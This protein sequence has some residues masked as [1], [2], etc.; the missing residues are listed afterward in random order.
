VCRIYGVFNYRASR[1]ELRAVSALQ[2]HGGPDEQTFAAAD[3]WAVG[4]NRLAI[5]E[6]DGGRQP[7]RLGRIAVVFNGELYNHADLR[8]DLSGRGYTFPDNCDGNVI[9]ALYDL[10][11]DGF[12]D[13]LDG[14]YAVAV[15]DLRGLPRLVL[16]TD[17]SGMKPLYYCRDEHNER[18]CFA[19]E[20]PALLGFTGVPVAEDPLG[21]ET[22][23]AG[24]TPFGER[25]MF[26]GINTLP[27]ASTA[28]VTA[29]GFSVRSRTSAS[30]APRPRVQGLHEAG[31]ELRDL[32]RTE[33]SRLLVADV[34]VAAVTSG[35]LDSSL[36]T[37]LAAERA[38]RLHTF[39]IAYA[40]DWPFD[41][42]HYA[43]E[44]ADL[45]GSEHHQVVLDPAHFG[46][47][48]EDVVWHLGQPNS[49]PISLSTYALFRAVR[50]AGF[51][52]ALTGDAADELFGGYA[53]M[54]EAAA[55]PAGA[56]WVDAYLDRLAAVPAALR[57]HLYTDDY[58]DLLSAAGGAL[59]VGLEETLRHGAGSRLD[60]ICAVEQTYRLPA[61][62]LRRV[63]HLSMAN[64]VEVRLPYCQ[65][66]VL[67]FAAGLR[68][69]HRVTPDGVKQVL[70][71]AADG[72]L[73]ISILNRPKQ[74]FT[75]PVTAMLAPG[76]PLWDLAHDALSGP[77]FRSDGRVRAAA[78][79]GL[80]ARQAARPSDESSQVL[81]A[82]MV[83]QLWR[84]QF[85]AAFHVPHSRLELR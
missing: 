40:G 6:P 10:Y 70:Y 46:D 36:I 12:T 29:E 11:G 27:R 50:D 83:H 84:R 66:A 32:L 44:V 52:V 69:E 55:A 21:L 23:L 80:F 78:V 67:R 77:E 63:D 64:S 20:L 65:P 8:A 79:D 1:R 56:D 13:H 18:F 57:R 59:P 85:F 14:M 41:E 35:G 7:F 75:L 5:M 68:D 81:W 47:L 28:T 62:H 49:D 53:R 17:A 34:P 26:Q 19:S 54:A 72:L 42:R 76:Q 82:L 51:K 71:R 9:P 43:R 37:I 39:N 16:A 25:T 45:A 4:N 60:R 58:V 30:M 73:P 38:Q 48:I 33:V 3:G 74:P 15:L 61:Y 24:K 31:L 2:R 22:Y